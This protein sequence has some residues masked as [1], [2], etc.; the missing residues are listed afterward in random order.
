[1]IFSTMTDLIAHVEQL[2]GSEGN[3]KIATAVAA[4]IWDEASDAS[5]L[6]GDDWS[7]FW[8]RYDDESVWLDLLD[9]VIA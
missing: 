9:E 5:Y 8:A 6:F 4:K 3:I 7:Q 1:M 2:L